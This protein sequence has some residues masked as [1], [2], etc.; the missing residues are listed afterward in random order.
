MLAAQQGDRVGAAVP[1]Y[2]VG[3]GRPR[4]VRRH[5]RRR[6]G[7]L[8]RAATTSTPS[9]RPARRSSRSAAE[10]GADV[11][12]H[13]YDA[14]HAFHNDTNKLGT[15]DAESARLAWERTVGFLKEKLA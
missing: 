1:F 3:P 14:G 9:S 13:Y 11:D 12:F 4:V 5:H 8:R 10:S 6:P 15:Y 2:G 7:P